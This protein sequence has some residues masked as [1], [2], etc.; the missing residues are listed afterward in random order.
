[1]ALLHQGFHIYCQQTLQDKGS[2]DTSIREMDSVKLLQGSSYSAG[3]CNSTCRKMPAR[4]SSGPR[5]RTWLKAR[6]RLWLWEFSGLDF[7]LAVSALSARG[8]KGKKG[9]CCYGRKHLEPQHQITFSFAVS[10]YWGIQQLFSWVQARPIFPYHSEKLI[11]IKSKNTGI[12]PF[13]RSKKL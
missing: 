2:Q 6:I 3:G 8:I 7:D 4:S 12:S 1:M 9:K 10:N 11:V 13:A 5:T